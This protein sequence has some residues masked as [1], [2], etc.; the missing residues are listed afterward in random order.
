MKKYILSAVLLIALHG[1]HTAQLPHITSIPNGPNKKAIITEQV[2]FTDVTISYHRPAVN[3]RQGKIWGQLIHKGFVNQNFG[4]NKLAPWRAGAN[5]NTIIEFSQDVQVEGNNLPKGKYGLFIAYDEAESIVIFSKKYD[6]WGS[7]FYDEADDALRVKVK[8]YQLNTSIEWLRYEFYNQ[9]ANSAVVTLEFDQ[10]AIP[11]K[12]EVDAKKQQFDL[13]DAELKN[14][15]GF[16]WQTLSKAADWCLQNNYKLEQGL[17]WAKKSS[18]DNGFGGNQQFNAINTTA[19]LLEK[20]GRKAEAATEIKRAIN[21]A[22]INELH[23][24]ARQLLQE[25]KAVEALEIFKINA[26]K[27]PNQFTTYAGLARGYA[28]NNNTKKALENAKKALPLAPND[29]NKKAVETMIENLKAGTGI[30]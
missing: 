7:Y 3:G 27:N 1:T 24:Y 16:T 23:Q 29:A 17:A 9:T 4:N 15:R 20:L 5:E 11:F 14:P 8:P 25:N 26:N 2:G 18:D 28:A 12:I 21:V 6:G 30:N 19:Q 10:L 22:N 13:L